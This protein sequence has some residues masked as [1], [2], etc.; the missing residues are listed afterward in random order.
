VSLRL[1]PHAKRVLYCAGG[2]I[3]DNSEPVGKQM[4]Y[5]AVKEGMIKDINGEF[6]NLTHLPLLS[7][8]TRRSFQLASWP[9]LGLFEGPL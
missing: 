4:E 7:F 6:L 9:S 1:L 3:L 2:F 8:A 5:R